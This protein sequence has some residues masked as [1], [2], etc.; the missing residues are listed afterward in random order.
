[1]TTTTTTPRRRNDDER[2]LS[3]TETFPSPSTAVQFAL[4]SLNGSVR[5]ER[6][7]VLEMDYEKKPPRVGRESNATDASP[8]RTFV[9]SPAHRRGATTRCESPGRRPPLR[10]P[11]ARVSCVD[12]NGD[13]D[14]DG[15]L[16]CADGTRRR[17]KGHARTR[18]PTTDDDRCFSRWSL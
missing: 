18:R 2:V 7:K 10:A 11:G 8:P 4:G 1:M 3:R 6:L 14:G 15:T 16:F 12:G 5:A 9:S 17:E 13:G